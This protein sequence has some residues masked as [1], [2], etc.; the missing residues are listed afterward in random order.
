MNDKDV[1]YLRAR[2][3]DIA[4]QQERI[5]DG[6]KLHATDDL[7]AHAKIYEQ[8]KALA[9]RQQSLADELSLYK[10]IY[11]GIKWV[12]ALLLLLVTLKFGDIPALFK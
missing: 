11:R 6:Q 2:M 7:A 10:T 1:G 5:L 9:D 4:R 8:M 3:E 12:G